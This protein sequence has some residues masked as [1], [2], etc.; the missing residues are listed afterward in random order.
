ML[1]DVRVGDVIEYSYSITGHN[2]VFNGLTEITLATNWRSYV[3]VARYRVLTPESRPLSVRQMNTN[4]VVK[5]QVDNEWIEYTI[6]LDEVVPNKVE[7]NQPDWYI[8]LSLIHI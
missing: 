6:E 7:N 4:A 8:G 3:D 2:P 1:R 5:S